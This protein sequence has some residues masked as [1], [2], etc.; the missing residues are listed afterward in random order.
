MKDEKVTWS[1]FVDSSSF[2]LLPSSFFLHPSSFILLP[3]LSSFAVIVHGDVIF[4]WFS[5]IL[6]IALFIGFAWV[7][8]RFGQERTSV[9]PYSG[10][11][12]R[13]ASDLK[14][15]SAEKVLHYLYDHQEYDNRPF[16]LKKAALC[17]ETGRIF[18][19]CVDLFGNINLNWSFLQKRYPGNY[20]SWGSLT[21]SQQDAILAIHDP[22]TGYQT[23]FS[24]KTAIPRLVE[25]EFAMSK[26]GPLYVDFETKVLLGWKQVPGTDLEVMIVQKPIK[27]ILTGLSK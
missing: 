6:V 2:I 7:A 20:V 9:S 18:P 8:W 17:R 16:D 3:C 13:K 4:F 5:V 22:L 27:V 25:P 21:K 11:P 19:K 14:F 23:E 26:P 10:M 1:L 12:L 15:Y 24:S